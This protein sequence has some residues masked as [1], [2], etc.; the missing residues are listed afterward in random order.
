MTVYQIQCLLLYY[1]PDIPACDLGQADGIIGDK[2]RAA[3]RAFQRR[4]GISEDG[5]PGSETQAAL[6][7][8]INTPLPAVEEPAAP[9]TTPTTTETNKHGAFWAEIKHFVPDEF[10][11]PCG[12]CGGF[13]VEMQEKLVRLLDTTIWNHFG[14]PITVIPLPPAN[15]HAG[16]SGIRCQAYN[17]SLR[18]SVPNS[19]H[20]QGKAADIIVRGFSGTLVNAYCQSLVKAGKLR[21]AYVIGGS[22]AVHIDIL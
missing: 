1:K 14:V 8:Y 21:Y 12:K 20:I 22:N 5:Q 15:A 2:T 9:E 11:C 7:K 16:G 18:G 13:P 3:V 10:R 17:D 19:R 6:K 4:V